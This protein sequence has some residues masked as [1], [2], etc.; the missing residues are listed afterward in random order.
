MVGGPSWVVR[1]GRQD[2]RI[3]S[4]SEASAQLPSPFASINQLKQNFAAKGLSVKDL[5]VLSG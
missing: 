1:T 5:V 2:G 4:A 3:S